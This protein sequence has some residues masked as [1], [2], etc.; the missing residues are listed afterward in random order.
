M[1]YTYASIYHFEAISLNSQSDDRI[2]FDDKD[3]GVTVLLAKDIDKHCLEI[4][5]GIA[6]ENMLLRGVFNPNKIA[7][8]YM[9]IQTEI[10][11]IQ[12][13]RNSKK[14]TSFIV[15]KIR[16]DVEL[17]I[18]E[19]QHIETDDFHVCSNAIDKDT[20][21]NQHKHTVNSIVSSISIISGSEYH[22][23]NFLNYIYFRHTNGKLLFSYTGKAATLRAICMKRFDDATIR[24]SSELINRLINNKQFKSVSRLLAQSLET[25]QDKFRAF[26][27]AWSA[28]E[29]FINKVF[30]QYEAKFISNVDNDHSSHGV[31]K[32]LERIQSVMKDKYR[33]TDK[34]TLIAS[35]LG[36]DIENDINLFNRI[37]KQRNDIYHGQAF[38]EEILPVEDARR[39]IS[40]Y[41]KKH[42]TFEDNA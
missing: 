17:N 39:L 30:V 40:V 10:S 23:E 2:I 18:N 11:K 1:E 42:L 4:D 21:F 32:Y 8:L 3:L 33:L 19:E 25:K 7:S 34:F 31:S 24:D 28:I 22:A 27:S 16:G 9:G 36:D 14:K 6:C 29:I 26:L 20:L 41:L 37:K 15:I 13:E 5:K 12:E 38:D 35:F